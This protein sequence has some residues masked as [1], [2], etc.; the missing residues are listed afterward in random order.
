M[1]IGGPRETD[2]S[3]IHIEALE[4]EKVAKEDVR[5][6]RLLAEG[7]CPVVGDYWH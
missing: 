1:P 6:S 7:L 3:H 2:I 5:D 4:G